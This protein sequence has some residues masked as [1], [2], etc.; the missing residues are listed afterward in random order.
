[1]NT[2]N[3]LSANI[4]KWSNTIK[5]FVG[6]L[7]TNCLSVF[8]HFVGLAL[9]GL[10]AIFYLIVKILINFYLP[11]SD[12]GIVTFFCNNS[13]TKNGYH[14]N[15]AIFQPWFR[16][17]F[18]INLMA[19]WSSQHYFSKE[20]LVFPYFSKGSF[21]IIKSHCRW[22]DQKTIGFLMITGWIKAD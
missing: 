3:S 22:N 10:I 11:L 16:R 9:K 8:D 17:M 6:K 7:P 13:K 12:R 15:L 18:C 19:M 5:Q 21:M 1:M 20:N 2:I 4:T 14:S